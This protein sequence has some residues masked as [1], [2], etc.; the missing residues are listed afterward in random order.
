ML[1]GALL[2]D[3]GLAFPLALPPE[4]DGGVALDFSLLGTGLALVLRLFR[5]TSVALGSGPAVTESL[6]GEPWDSLL[7]DGLL[8]RES[9]LSDD[10]S[11]GPGDD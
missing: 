8:V 7:D 9:G 2:E 1:D 6:L 3:D 5:T 4:L 10:F 11:A